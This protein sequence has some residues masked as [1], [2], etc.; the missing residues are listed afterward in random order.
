M[1]NM[2]F[3]KGNIRIEGNH[4]GFPYFPIFNSPLIDPNFPPK[5]KNI[6]IYVEKT[7]ESDN[8]VDTS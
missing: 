4:L 2:K 7:Q 6:Y 3:Q 8:K 1:E 5:I